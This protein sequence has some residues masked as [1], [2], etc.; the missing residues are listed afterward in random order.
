VTT[1]HRNDTGKIIKSHE[2]YQAKTFD[3][4]CLLRMLSKNN[5]KAIIHY[6]VGYDFMWLA[7]YD[8]VV[9]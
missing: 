2:T 6:L 4:G 3:S 8:M 1:C 7:E 9:E 5:S